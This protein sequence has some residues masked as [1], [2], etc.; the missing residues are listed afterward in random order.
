M[1]LG[2]FVA[3]NGMKANILHPESAAAAPKTP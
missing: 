1:Q 2:D 3:D